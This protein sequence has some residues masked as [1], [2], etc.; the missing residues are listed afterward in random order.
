M[1]P[2]RTITRSIL[3]LGAALALAACGGEP[4]KTTY[5]A[6]VTDEGGGDLVVTQENPDEVKV[7]TPDTPMTSVPA[8]GATATPAE[9]NPGDAE[10]IAD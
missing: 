1:I 7:K 4:E 2:F 9:D 8:D 5:K 10:P 6:D 3:P